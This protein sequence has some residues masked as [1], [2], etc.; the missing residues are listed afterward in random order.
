MNWGYGILIVIILF[1]LGMSGLVFISSK[2]HIDMMDDHYY[3]REL[4]H[5]TL[6]DGEENLNKS[7]GEIAVIDSQSFIV[8]VISESVVNNIKNGKIHFLRESDQRLDRSIVLNP[9]MGKQ[10]IEKSLFVKGKYQARFSWTNDGK[11]FYRQLP[12]EIL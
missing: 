2:Q 7:G 11:S 6:I 8:I 4:T 10:T 5:Q 9:L 1:V 12:V 3:E